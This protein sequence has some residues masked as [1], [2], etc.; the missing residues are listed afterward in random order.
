M[1]N[2]IIEGNKLIAEFMGWSKSPYEHLPNKMYKDDKG[3]HV[4]QLKYN[5]SWDWLMPVV[6]KVEEFGYPTLVKSDYYRKKLDYEVCIFQKGTGELLIEN[7]F[8]GQTKIMTTWRAVVEFIR[9]YNQNKE[10]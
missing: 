5:S 7:D 6:E 3:I 9:W 2:E 4:D 8:G 10:N 1:A